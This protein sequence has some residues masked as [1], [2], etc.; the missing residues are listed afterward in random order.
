MSMKLHLYAAITVAAGVAA[1]L[2][3]LGTAQGQSPDARSVHPRLPSVARDVTLMTARSSKGTMLR[4]V[5]RKTEIGTCVMLSIDNSG[6]P[7]LCGDA[8][9]PV[10]FWTERGDP[11]ER[12]VVAGATDQ[13]ATV[14][15]VTEGGR[16]IEPLAKAAGNAGNVFM[17]NPPSDGPSEVA[18]Q[19][20]T[21]AGV[22]VSSQRIQFRASSSNEVPQG[23]DPH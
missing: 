8:P 7:E 12:F 10:L 14:E 13:T 5:E 18:I 3:V 19:K 1:A 23:F 2:F 16:R 4:V 17:L 20:R 6:G 9:E 22:V 21:A 15:A 11:G